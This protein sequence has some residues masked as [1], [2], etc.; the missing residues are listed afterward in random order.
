MRT[1]HPRTGVQYA[2]RLTS[3]RC[4]CG[5][6]GRVCARALVVLC[7]RRSARLH[8]RFSPRPLPLLYFAPFPF[9]PLTHILLRGRVTAVLYCTVGSRKGGGRGGK[10]GESA[11]AV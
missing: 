9:F 7:D 2:C 8:F 5:R 3:A 1:H 10:G 11:S 6:V 4:A